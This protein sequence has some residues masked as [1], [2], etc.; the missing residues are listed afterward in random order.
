MTYSPRVAFH[1]CNMMFVVLSHVVETVTGRWLG[2][3]LREKLWEPLGMNSTYFDLD[4]ALA[5]PNHFADGYIWDEHNK[6]FRE[7]PRMGITEVSGAGGVLSTALD[8]AKWVKCL[9]H[10]AAPL[11]EAVHRDIKTVRSIYSTAPSGGVDLIL[12]ALGWERMTFRG[13]VVYAHSGGMHAYG[14]QVFW[15]PE[16]KYGVVAFGNTALTSNVV[17]EVLGWRLIQD[18]LGIPREEQ[19]DF[20]AKYAA[21]LEYSIRTNILQVA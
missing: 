15:L 19:Y 11:S 20:G 17:E 10:E 3:V 13:H 1:Y 9:L 5:A 8:Y 4:E 6:T 7:V 12:Y 14:A 21:L 16:H 18:K 2:D